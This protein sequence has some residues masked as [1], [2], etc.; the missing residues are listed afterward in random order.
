VPAYRPLDRSLTAPIAEPA[1]PPTA[2]QLLGVPAVC[3]LDG[4]LQIEDWRG[5]LQQCNADRA[6]AARV[7]AGVPPA[8][9]GATP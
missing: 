8:T 1:A 3:A 7:S 9:V 4:L 6:T 5:V 2:C